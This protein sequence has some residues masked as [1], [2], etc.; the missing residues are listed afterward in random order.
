MIKY[1]LPQSE[2]ANYE[3]W[4]MQIADGAP[5]NNATFNSWCS[6][7]SYPYPP[8]NYT[9]LNFVPSALIECLS[10]TFGNSGGSISY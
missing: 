1:N 10:D 4:I 7:W 5:I 2:H 9:D 3:N 6:K 8:N